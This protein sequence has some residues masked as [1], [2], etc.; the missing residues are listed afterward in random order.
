MTCLAALAVAGV[1]L[2][3]GLDAVAADLADTGHHG[4]QEEPGPIHGAVGTC[5]FVIAA[6]G[7]IGAAIATRG[8]RGFH[9]SVPRPADGAVA[10]ARS[11]PGRLR[12]FELCVMRT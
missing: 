10:V 7:M 12:R 11:G 4:P 8:R 3:H 6:L 9:V 1:L 5:V 2:M